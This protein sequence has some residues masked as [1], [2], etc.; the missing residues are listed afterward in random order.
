[1][2]K[3]FFNITKAFLLGLA[4]V[5]VGCSD[6]DEDIKD[7]NNRI[8]AV[9]SQIT[10]EIDL[11]K[12][13]LDNTKKDLNAAKDAL[14]ALQVKH[15]ADIAAL[16]ASDETLKSSIAEANNA[17]VALK[18]DLT[19][20]ESA[21]NNKVDGVQAELDAK[22]NAEI[23]T[24]NEKIA[25]AEAQIE[26]LK[27]NVSELNTKDAEL[28]K[29]IADL[30]E[31]M[32]ALKA[33]LNAL[34]SKNAEGIAGN[35]AAIKALQENMAQHA[36]IF[37]E[38]QATVAAQIGALEAK[39]AQI[40]TSIATINDAITR[41]DASIEAI[42]S[43]KVNVT[44]F[45]A[46]KAE[47]LAQYTT[48][49]DAIF[50]LEYADVKLNQTD[51][52]LSERIYN[53]KTSLQ[54][55][56]DEAFGNIGANTTAIAALQSEVAANLAKINATNAS[57][58]SAIDQ[59]TAAI[60]ALEAKDKALDAKDE[61]LA[62]DIVAKYAE[63]SKSIEGLVAKDAAI[64][65]DIQ[66]K[67][68]E[69]KDQISALIAKDAE[70]D[71]K[72][73][74]ECKK[75][76]DELA[77]SV[78]ALQDAD[79]AIAADAAAANAALAAEFAAE[80][81]ALA[82]S[83]E[84]KSAELDAA[85][86]ALEK[87]MKDADDEIKA[88]LQTKY[89]ALV[90]EI[91][92][93][94]EEMKAADDAIKADLQAKYDELVA[95]RVAL[96]KEL[97]DADAAISA[98][99][100]AKYDELVAADAAIIADA[101]AQ[102]E[103]LAAELAAKVK[104]LQAADAANADAIAANA[105]AIA[106]NAKAIADNYAE[107]TAAD[108]ALAAEIA[109]KYADLAADLQAKY[110]ELVA[111]DAAI[112]DK[113]DEVEAEL[114]AMIEKEIA[115]REAADAD[116]AADVK[117]KYDELM[118]KCEALAK[119][120]GDI[121]TKLNGEVAKLTA[122]DTEIETIVAANYAELSATA[123]YLQEKIN[124][125]ML[126]NG[127]LTAENKD[128]AAA[129]EALAKKDAELAADLLAK[130]NELKDADAALAKA[131]KDLE[132]AL[133]TKFAEE[134]QKSDAAQ[135]LAFAEVWEKIAAMDATDEGFAAQIAS[136]IA[137][138]TELANQIIALTA[139]VNDNT[140]RIAALETSLSDFQKE[141]EAYKSNI[142]EVVSDLKDHIVSVE[143]L[144][145]KL[146]KETTAT[147][148]T[149]KENLEKEFAAVYQEI[150]DVKSELNTNISK[151]MKRIQSIVYVP[152]YDDGKATIKYAKMKT[153]SANEPK[154]IEAASTI[155][156]QV[157]PAACAE[158]I[159]TAYKADN[160]TLMFDV[161]PVGLA[162]TRSGAAPAALNIKN[163]EVINAEEGLIEITFWARNFAPEFFAD[164]ASYS[165][166]LI[167]NY[168]DDVN[169][170]SANLSS[171]YTNL[172]PS[173]VNTTEEIT[174][175]L[176]KETADYDS[177]FIEYTMRNSE[178]A[179]EFAAFE[180]EGKKDVLEGLNVVY[181]VNGEAK[182]YAQMIADGYDVAVPEFSYSVMGYNHDAAIVVDADNAANGQFTQASLLSFFDYDNIED[183]A[184]L[185]AGETVEVDDAIQPVV[186]LTEKATA[187]TV[188]SK[189]LYTGTFNVDGFELSAEQ[190]VVVAPN[191][192]QITTSPAQ[193][194]WNYADD[195]EADASR[196]DAD[197]SNDIA[198]ARGAFEFEISEDELAK[199]DGLSLVDVY[200]SKTSKIEG[201][202]GAS[203]NA[204]V[205]SANTFKFSQFSKFEWNKTYTLKYK[206]ANNKS[207]EVE[208]EFV[209]KTVDRD[210]ETVVEISAEENVELVK[211]LTFSALEA[212][213]LNGDNGIYA[214][215][216]DV[217]NIGNSEAD[218]LN[219]VLGKAFASDIKALKASDNNSYPVVDPTTTITVDGAAKTAN[220]SFDYNDFSF[221]PTQVVY[222][223]EITLWYG[224]K[225]NLTYTVNFDM[226]SA[227]YNFEHVDLWVKSGDAGL[228]SDVQGNYSPNKESL[229]LT[230]F[231]VSNIDM[232][233]A[234]VVVDK[235][236]GKVV[237]DR[238]TL[239]L[240]TEFEIED[241]GVDAGIKFT[242][243]VLAYNGKT[244][245]VNV[246]GNLYLEH[247]N[248]ARIALE[249]VFDT[250][251]AYAN[252]VVNKFDPFS[253]LFAEDIV[254][255][256]TEIET[257]KL[258]VRSRFSIYETRDGG[259]EPTELGANKIKVDLL[260]ANGKYIVGNGSNGWASSKSVFGIYGG[261][262][263]PKMTF[264]VAEDE[265]PDK[266]AHVIKFY[267]G[268]DNEKFL[269][270][271]NTAN[272]ELDK[273]VTIEVVA[274]ID[275]TWGYKEATLN[276]T[277]RNPN[278]K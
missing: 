274:T 267:I 237:A 198:Y 242:K 203:I 27:A 31:E 226:P 108:K 94:K 222:T 12:V 223:D 169:Y 261:V 218:F 277:F 77:A 128:Q 151:L 273:D 190:Y 81:A 63:L 196:L 229:A 17:I 201:L 200:K 97:K 78:K 21:L 199:L 244:N 127:V 178:N 50:A 20:A 210:R 138:D 34:I 33:E 98:D 255:D 61:E 4:L 7:L 156:Y 106:A 271:D 95:A 28:D 44:D 35:A 130:Y 236:T 8:D 146:D 92:A 68:N 90:K 263:N 70:L 121:L 42:Q 186:W 252:Y 174:V 214:Q 235:K 158:A 48:L 91:A 221:I 220:V 278:K 140:D 120:D 189:L 88:D 52:E 166:S 5:A 96:E 93:V 46:Y 36:Q 85:I 136:L 19:A 87:D 176:T 216:K 270:F 206:F 264:T 53:V 155:Q 228:Y 168:K 172:V 37:V 231:S 104:D 184:E 58:N 225:V 213:E 105:T 71:K 22:I 268:A 115:D 212:M 74:D 262:S 208:F 114:I 181:K 69:L 269:S 76:A 192:V 118:A 72:I 272:L 250:N 32:A 224:Q 40:E 2:K 47:V 135:A 165:T 111:A 45:E 182:T 256:I 234:F 122:K 13:D 211:D 30:D 162:S 238:E 141:Y 143:G 149:M 245:E 67:Y 102:Y 194:V 241:A 219:D 103:A 204:A 129:L 258:D 49:E 227:A 3:N 139:T 66:S 18:G 100:K 275:Y 144:A 26:G 147:F 247:T 260:A 249:T 193:F 276:V 148:N 1:M 73:A 145:V 152:D 119:A 89:D 125:L 84:D 54:A 55:S 253:D 133:T 243:N 59:F 14:A 240:V 205:P 23:A 163:V 171:S 29:K 239:G 246:K 185:A 116:A 65:A 265:I 99:V 123:A 15:D 150:E 132:N 154:I 254:I 137:K 82:K 183:A 112:N 83:I 259:D 107:L 230:A 113:V 257:Y 16:K 62:L 248:G 60:A 75:I 79:A 38:Y 25:A 86:K 157:Y 217:Y 191:Q 197:E 57:L 153:A 179:L 124:M 6:Y 188:G 167:L 177:L 134:L 41:I 180:T 170:S 209:I 175:A 109:A 80:C 187:S 10:G 202:E 126:V 117:A 207:V 64:E 142:D 215:L 101:K 39:D 251:A 195:A 266:Y 56:L 161:R 131:D 11:T 43:G 164:K 24:V 233:K 160:S 51:K 9:T 110:D 159:A 232:D 173:G